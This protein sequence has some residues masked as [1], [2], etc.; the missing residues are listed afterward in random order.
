[1]HAAGTPYI[2]Y[3][4]TF[5]G[6]LIDY[7]A[8]FGFK[9]E[10]GG[11]KHD[12]SFTTGGNQQLYTVEHTLNRGLGAGSPTSFKPGG[13]KFT[14]LIGNYDVSKEVT[15]NFSIGFGSE[16]RQETFKIIAGDTASYVA[17]GANS[18]P[19]IRQENATTNSRFNFGA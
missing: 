11:W 4:P 12:V 15:D 19:G 9:N 1:M 2:G 16:I 8:T 3:G 14:N 5:E 7:N 10:K 6:D 13:F 17:E 18:F